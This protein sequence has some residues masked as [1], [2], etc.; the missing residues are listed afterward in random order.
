MAVL[1]YAIKET[2]CAEALLLSALKSEDSELIAALKAGGFEVAPGSLKEAW[3]R[4]M[5]F[6]YLG[7]K[8]RTMFGLKVEEIVNPKD[9]SLGF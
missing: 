4:G 5:L 3:R 8:I 6:D 9:N 7:C 2:A 1:M